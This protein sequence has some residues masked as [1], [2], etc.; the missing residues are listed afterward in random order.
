MLTGLYFIVMLFGWPLLLVMSL[1]G[2]LET[3]LAL[4]R[5]RRGAP[6]AAAARLNQS[7]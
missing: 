1:L 5:P 2:L 4:A 6:A 3:M 7:P